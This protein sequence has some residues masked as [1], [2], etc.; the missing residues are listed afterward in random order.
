V[1]WL[2]RLRPEVE[3]DILLAA[4]WYESQRQGLGAAF[5]DEISQVVASLAGNALLYAELFDG[6]RR[7]FAKRFPYAVYF[8]LI[9]DEVVVISI[10]HMRRQR[11]S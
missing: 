10:L 11:S 3:L 7:V 1:T 2:V 8:K 4:G 9:A 5:I 6:I